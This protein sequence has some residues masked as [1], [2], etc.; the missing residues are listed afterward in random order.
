ME[1]FFY[2]RDGQV[3][4]VLTLNG[5]RTGT[6]YVICDILSLISDKNRIRLLELGF[7]KGKKVKVITKSLLKKTL[8]IEISGYTLSLRKDIADLVVVKQ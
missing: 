2:E 3:E 6:T 8:L 4:E 7:I 5:C 1:D